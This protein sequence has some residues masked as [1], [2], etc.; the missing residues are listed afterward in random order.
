MALSGKGSKRETRDVRGRKLND[1]YMLSLFLP[2]HVKNEGMKGS[3]TK[4][5]THQQHQIC[6]IL[7]KCPLGCTEHSAEYVLNLL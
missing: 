6:M 7:K 4:K 5:G 1:M 2:S 3:E